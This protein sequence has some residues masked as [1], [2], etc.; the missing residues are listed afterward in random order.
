ML[1]IDFITSIVD[2]IFPIFFDDSLKVSLVTNI[3]ITHTDRT[4]FLFL[5]LLQLQVIQSEYHII[6][7]IV[8]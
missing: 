5:N 7:V 6:C 8:I 4:Q 2:N 1:A 3:H